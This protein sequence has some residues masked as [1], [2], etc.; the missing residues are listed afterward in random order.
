MPDDQSP[1]ATGQ[2]QPSSSPDL[3]T[4]AATPQL[5][6]QGGSG[7]RPILMDLIQGLIKPRM[8]ASAPGQM[9]TPVSRA[10][11]FENFLGNFVYALGQGFANEGHGPG[12]AMR[13]AGAAIGAPMNLQAQQRQ[14]QAQR[15]QQQAEAEHSQAQAQLARAQA[16]PVNV[17]GIQGKIPAGSIP[18][19][20]GRERAAE[21]TAQ[22][23]IQKQLVANQGQQ[24][25]EK[26]K[27]GSPLAQAQASHLQAQDDLARAHQD[28]LMNPNN[29]TFRQKE[30]DIQARLALAQQNLKLRMQSNDLRAGDMSNKIYQP[31]M[32]ADVRLAT[33]RDN[34]QE[35]LKGD[36]QAM[37]SLLT[38]HIGMTLGL[39]KG[40]RIT[41]D[42]LKE[43]E[44]S[45]PWL[46]KVQAKFNDE[47]YLSGATLAPEQMKQMVGLAEKLRPMSWQKARSQSRAIGINMEPDPLPGLDKVPEGPPIAARPSAGGSGGSVRF[48]ANGRIYN[49]PSSRQREF[50]SEF[51]A[52]TQV[53]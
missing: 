23:G 11:T 2:F 42:I 12:A 41:K 6:P 5:A 52:A 35:G 49:I 40:A 47:G 18:A 43:A 33:M 48:R 8:Q 27:E 24:T 20:L 34:L 51:P 38:N 16:Q 45:T 17:P 44:S 50:L 1:D 25:V 53:K 31:A 39:Q 10:Q 15:E 26:M 3:G 7:P 19:L 30:R 29:P 14:A 22:G 46:A 32:D 21:A 9:A 36:Q 37:L 28:V 4:G 13:G